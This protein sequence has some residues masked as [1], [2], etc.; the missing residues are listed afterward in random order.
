MA[1]QLADR[2]AD[3]LCEILSARNR[4]YDWSIV[5]RGSEPRGATVIEIPK[6]ESARRRSSPESPSQESAMAIGSKAG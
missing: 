2:Y 1:N 4:N 3:A 5:Q 6:P